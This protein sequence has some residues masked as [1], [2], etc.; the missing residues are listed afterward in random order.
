M[1]IEGLSEEVTSE[2]KSKQ[3]KDNVIGI[4]GRSL[5]GMEIMNSKA[6]RQKIS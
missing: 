4:C 1:I 3:S 6:L 2:Q 5:P